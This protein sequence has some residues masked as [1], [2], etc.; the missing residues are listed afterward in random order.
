[1]R[2]SDQMNPLNKKLFFACLS[3]IFGIA[4]LIIASFLIEP[5]VI[6][7]TPLPQP[8]APVEKEEITIILVGD[9][10]LNRGVEDMINE[11]GSEDFK[12]PFLRTVDYLNKAD[13]VFGNLE[14]VISDKGS[15]IGSTYSFRA[16]PKAIEGLTSASF[17]V[18]SVANNHIFDYG[19]AAM[20]DSFSRLKEAGIAYVGGGFNEEEA[21]TP[22]IKEI[23]GTKIAFL[24]YT[25]LGSPN[26]IAKEENSGIAWLKKDRIEGDQSKG[27]NFTVLFL[28]AT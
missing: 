12:F 17:D 14:S 5:R 25:N 27:S 2:K 4:F 18:I 24:A 9:I 15:K 16:D 6:E 11:H 28:E 23:N 19:R 22:V 7:I 13:I 21:Y 26:W 8:I 1:M 20:E 10:M 3:L